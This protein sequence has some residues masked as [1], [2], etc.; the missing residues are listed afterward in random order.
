MVWCKERWEAFRNIATHDVEGILFR[1]QTARER[2]TSALLVDSEERRRGVVT[3]QLER[4]CVERRLAVVI[5]CRHAHHIT[6][7]IQILSD[8]HVMCV[9]FEAWCVLVAAHLQ[10]DFRCGAFARV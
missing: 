10:R 1:N 8:R 9:A 7:H 3:D 4:Q 5:S 6:V 2:H